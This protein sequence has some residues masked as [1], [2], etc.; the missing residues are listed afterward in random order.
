MDARQAN[1]LIERYWRS[2]NAQDVEELR[3]VFADD[4]AIEWP[5]SGER[6]HG[7]EACIN[8][9]TN[10]PGGSPQFLGMSR[11]LGEGGVWVGEAELLY[12]GDKKYMV[13]SIFEIA[14]GR[15]TH[16]IDYFAEPFP[17]PE[18]RKQW[19]PAE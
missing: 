8:I 12:P 16:E 14:N 15:I 6:F 7:K 9:F 13:V 11:V 5:Q 4:V 10:Y 19:L 3:Q 1:D 2:A 17:A 18:W